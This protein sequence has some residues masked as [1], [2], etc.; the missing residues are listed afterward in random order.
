MRGPLFLP[1]GAS[2][3]PS[4]AGNN[5][6]ERGLLVRPPCPYVSRGQGKLERAAI[7]A[8]KSDAA[9]AAIESDG[10]DLFVVF[11]GKRIATSIGHHRQRLPAQASVTERRYSAPACSTGVDHAGVSRL[12]PFQ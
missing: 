8:K 11:E 2:R 1:P 7:M 6:R 3:F 4:S 5:G 12:F 9:A 10:T